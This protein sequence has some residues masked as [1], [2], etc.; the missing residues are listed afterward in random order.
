M[1]M[2][3]N[4]HWKVGGAK[5]FASGGKWENEGSGSESHGSAEVHHRHKQ[6]DIPKQNCVYGGGGFLFLIGS[7]SSLLC[8]PKLEKD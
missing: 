6:A 8:F 3:H 2:E 1:R 4:I 5:N 7:V